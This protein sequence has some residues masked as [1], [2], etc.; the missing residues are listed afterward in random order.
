MKGAYTF[1]HGRFNLHYQKTGSGEACWLVF[2][3]FGRSITAMYPIASILEKGGMV[4]SFDLFFHGKSYFQG[5]SLVSREEWVEAMQAF[6]KENQINRFN[7]AGFSMGC[8]LMAPLI[9]AFSEKIDK[10]LFIAPDGI[11]VSFW[12]RLAT[13]RLFRNYFRLM[14]FNPRV[15][16]KITSILK[17][18]PLVDRQ[19]LKFAEIQMMV[20]KRR[21]LVYRS[22]MAYRKLPI[23]VAKLVQNLN[24]NNVHV[25]VILG[26]QDSVIKGKAV[27]ELIQGLK[28][29]N[30]IEVDSNHHNLVQNAA[31][32]L[33]SSDIC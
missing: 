8:R 4:F 13:G 21:L 17:K 9:E 16:F 2:H 20:R 33:K 7:L 18:I 24:R 10:V 15:F 19:L 3:G 27:H 23:P 31:E 22:W 29:C 14:V 1:L 30:L 6:F 5:E 25:I 12:Y 11:N 32:V 28:Y 26:K